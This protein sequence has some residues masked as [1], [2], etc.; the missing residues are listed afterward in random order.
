MDYIFYRDGQHL[1]LKP[2]QSQVVFDKPVEGLF[3]S[4]HYGVHTRFQLLPKA[5]P[6]TP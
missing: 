3:V 1:D 2:I 6:K 4:D 5:D